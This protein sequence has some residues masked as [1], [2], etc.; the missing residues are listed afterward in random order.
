MTKKKAMEC[1]NGTVVVEIGMTEGNIKECGK[2]E[3]S[4]EKENFTI[5]K[6]ALGKE[7]FGMK[8]RELDGLMTTMHQV[9]IRSL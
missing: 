3:N 5:L 1:L 6:K 7:E 8:G 2:T 4:M 9:Q